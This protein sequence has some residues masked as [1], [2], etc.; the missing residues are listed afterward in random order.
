MICHCIFPMHNH[1]AVWYFFKSPDPV[2]KTIHI[3]MSADSF[4][5]LDSGI[6]RDILSKQLY[7]LCT[8]N[9]FSSKR[10]DCLISHKTDR[11]FRTP[12]IVLQ[13]MPDPSCFA[14]TGCRQD[15]FRFCIK[16]DLSGLVTGNRRLQTPEQQR[17]DPLIYQ[18]HCF[19]IKTSFDI[20]I[21]HIRSFDCKR[22]VHIYFKSRKFR[23]QILFFDLTDKVQNL[24]RTSNRK[25]RNH[26]IAAFLECLSQNPCKLSHIIWN[27]LTMCT[28]SVCRFDHQIVCLFY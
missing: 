20:F 3:C 10:S 28:V 27:I 17:I 14:H 13:M 18:F 6:D 23:K 9:Q 26:H 12:Q 24:L 19:L 8:L 5:Y 11:A 4:Q 1:Y 16:V 22:T 25:R 2:Q 7:T 21:K 15:N